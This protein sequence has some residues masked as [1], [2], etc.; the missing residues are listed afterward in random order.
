MSRPAECTC[1]ED[2]YEPNCPYYKQHKLHAEWVEAFVKDDEVNKKR[3]EDELAEIEA[4]VATDIVNESNEQNNEFKIVV[5]HSA[6]E[7]EGLEEPVHPGLL[8]LH[9]FAWNGYTGDARQIDQDEH[10]VSHG[11]AEYV[12]VVRKSMEELNAQMMMG[13]LRMILSQS[14]NEDIFVET[15]L[16]LNS[17]PIEVRD[18]MLATMLVGIANEAK[19]DPNAVHQAMEMLK[20]DE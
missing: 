10:D 17:L 9:A 15:I 4:Q 5:I 11:F 16:R 3:I 18:N 12:D 6:S 2:A 14:P 1:P 7:V 8:V 13:S 19:D 20:N